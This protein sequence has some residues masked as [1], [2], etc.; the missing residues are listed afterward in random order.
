[1]SGGVLYL[2]AGA[3]ASVAYFMVPGLEGNGL[4]FSLIGLSAAGAILVGALRNRPRHRLPWFLFA[5]AQVSF[6]L[7]DLCYYAFDA[8]FPSG[9]DVFYLAVYPLLIAGVL[10][11]IRS[12]S[13]GRDRGSLLDASIITVGLGL[14]AWVF[15]I[16]P[17][18]HLQGVGT[19]ARVMSIAYPLMDVLLLAV[20]A[21]LAMGS[22]TRPL[23]FYL[24]GLGIVSL[25]AADSVYGYLEL[26]NGYGQGGLLDAGWLVYYLLWGTAALLPGMRRIEEPSAGTAPVLTGRRLLPL[27]AATLI[28][29]AVGIIQS[30]QDSQAVLSISAVASAV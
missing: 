29:P 19:L 18:A 16:E 27:A 30:I 9:G 24:I 10:L 23:S 26:H 28:A 5:A 20:A 8:D 22:G 3:A 12:R 6:V 1:M 2:M 13:P 21:R 7:G 11:L 14:L 25:L 4:V 15:L 17:N